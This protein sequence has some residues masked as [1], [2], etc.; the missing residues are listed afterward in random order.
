MHSNNAY[1]S[2]LS[3]KENVT[4]AGDLGITINPSTS[5]MVSGIAF[6]SRVFVIFVDYLFKFVEPDSI[7]YTVF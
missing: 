5:S 4:L 6:V 1:S 7:F 3:A 2:P